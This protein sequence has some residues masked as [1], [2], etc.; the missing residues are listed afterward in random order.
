MDEMGCGAEATN[1][2]HVAKGKQKP[3]RNKAEEGPNVCMIIISSWT[4]FCFLR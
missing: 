1:L 3:F 4:E 2:D